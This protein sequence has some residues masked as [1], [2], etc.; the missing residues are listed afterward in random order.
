MYTIREEF[1]YSL[2]LSFSLYLPLLILIFDF[3]ILYFS[4]LIVFPFLL[5]TVINA[6]ISG[7]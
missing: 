1:L 2:L 4:C 7:L 3:N 5:K 6:D